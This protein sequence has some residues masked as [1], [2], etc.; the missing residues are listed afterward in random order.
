MNQL[1]IALLPPSSAKVTKEE[2]GNARVLTC[3]DIQQEIE[4]NE[5]RDYWI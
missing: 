5:K 1:R 3:T 2:P 4:P